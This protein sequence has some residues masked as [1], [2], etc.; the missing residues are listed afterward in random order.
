MKTNIWKLQSDKGRIS[1]ANTSLQSIIYLISISLSFEIL[2]K[3]QFLPN[4]DPSICDS[5]KQSVLIREVRPATNRAKLTAL[6]ICPPVGK[7]VY[8]L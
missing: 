7:L 6:L 4:T 3:P 8:I 2:I 5:V 1:K